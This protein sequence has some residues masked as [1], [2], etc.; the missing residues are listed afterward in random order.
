LLFGLIHSA[1]LSFSRESSDS[2]A[3]PMGAISVPEWL[4]VLK[5]VEKY[6]FEDFYIFLIHICYFISISY[7]YNEIN[8]DTVF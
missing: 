4:T 5:K 7:K 2:W 6:L 3:Y 8:S 1:I